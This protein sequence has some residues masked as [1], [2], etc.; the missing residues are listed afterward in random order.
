MN[1]A[2]LKAPQPSL[3]YQIKSAAN[4]FN[5]PMP[6]EAIESVDAVLSIY[7][8]KKLRAQK[9]IYILGLLFW[10][11]CA[12]LYFY[13][14]LPLENITDAKLLAVPFAV[15]AVAIAALYI[16]AKNK[17][18]KLFYQQFAQAS[19][20]TF[21][22]NGTTE[23][24]NGSLFSIG[25]DQTVECDIHGQ[26]GDNSV[27]LYNFTYT[28]GS[29][30][31]SHIYQSTMFKIN[32]SHPLANLL[33]VI[34]S[35]RFGGL[36]PQFPNSKKLRLEEAYEKYFDLY[37]EEK[38]EVEALQIFNIHFLEKMKS[39]WA[40]F[41]IEFCDQQAYIYS[42]KIITTRMEL[43]NMFTLAKYLAEELEPKLYA[44][45]GSVKAMSEL[46]SLNKH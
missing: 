38:M 20:F 29:G 42:N 23:G 44:M 1:P 39:T 12:L 10:L 30:K 14:V 43:E 8:N 34:D 13:A 2:N 9:H 11:V 45:S 15:P 27:R 33:L 22:E 5:V 37:V 3:G 26:V 46:N 16:N 24:L 28:V 31:N 32:F 18:L 6:T 41:S 36:S 4:I 21:Q 19:G 40:Q 7:I 35:A 25:H 17:V